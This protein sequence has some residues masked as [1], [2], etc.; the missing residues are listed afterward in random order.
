LPLFEIVG[1]TAF[2]L[3]IFLGLFSTLFGLPGTIVI[4]ASA[5]VYAIFTGFHAIGIKIMIALIVL[6]VL[7]ESLEFL[8]GMVGAKRFSLTRPGAIA[9]VV[10]GTAGCFIMT[11]L[12]MGLGTLT[13]ALFGSFAGLSCVEL[14]RERSLTPSARAT[15][16]ALWGGM[17]GSM[18]KCF[19][20]LVM[21]IIVL[22]SIYS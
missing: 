18:V 11:P 20:A 14:V 2:I 15:V 17:A 4:V 10:G 6:S 22:S 21:V 16:G 9:A 1:L 8:M 12:L 19:F 3:V 13:G 5:I 7:A